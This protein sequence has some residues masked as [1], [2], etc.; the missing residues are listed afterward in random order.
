MTAPEQAGRCAA[1]PTTFDHQELNRMTKTIWAAVALA[2]TAGAA[3]AQSSVTIYGFLDQ[4]YGKN[5]GSPVKGLIDSAGSRIGFKGTED[6]GGGLKASFEIE[7]RFD[8]S[9][10]TA[11]T[12]FWKGRSYV[13][14]SGGF[15]A[16]KLGRWWSQA[17]LYGQYQ[18]DP[19][20]NQTIAAN[21]GA[22]GCGSGCVGSFWNDNS[23]TYNLDAGGFSFG[24]QVVAEVAP[25][26]DRPYNLGVSYSAGGLWVGVGHENPGNANDV[27]N[28]ATVTYDFGSA[29]L[30]AGFGQGRNT[31]DV[32]V[33][34]IIVGGSVTLG[35]GQIIGSYEQH[36]VA[37]ATVVSR[38]ALGYQYHLS[39]RTKLFTTVA[40]DSKA[41]ASKTGYDLGILHSF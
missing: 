15:G 32:K 4:A 16:V 37:D 7:N 39:K 40:N 10:G 33:R 25:G 9:T 22:V 30:S 23:I 17:Y 19:F 12:P 1:D 14:L 27:W 21:Y 5:I 13:G 36:K 2:A 20:G 3:Q 29:K 35:L 24:A 6:L 28:Q 34:N 11:S 31:A 38:A 41:A 26:G 18:A 8:P